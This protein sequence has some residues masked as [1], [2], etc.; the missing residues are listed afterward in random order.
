[1]PSLKEQL[2]TEK[3]FGDTLLNP[4]TVVGNTVTIPPLR[5][6]EQNLMVIGRYHAHAGHVSA[7]ETCYGAAALARGLIRAELEALGLVEK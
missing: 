2:E 7:A 3:Q 4:S 5:D 6:L 1:M